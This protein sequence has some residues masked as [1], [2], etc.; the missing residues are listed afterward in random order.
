MCLRT[1]DDVNYGLTSSV[2]KGFEKSKADRLPTKN[3]E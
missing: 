3:K 1:K 2:K